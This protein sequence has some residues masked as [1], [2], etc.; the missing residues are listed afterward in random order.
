MTDLRK[1]PLPVDPPW[2]E[3]YAVKR[4]VGLGIIVFTLTGWMLAGVFALVIW[5]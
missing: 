5:V 1:Y 4:T 2:L 3:E